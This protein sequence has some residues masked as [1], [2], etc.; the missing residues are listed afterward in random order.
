[1]ERLAMN[2]E[3]LKPKALPTTKTVAETGTRYFK[4]DTAPAHYTFIEIEISH[5]IMEMKT[6]VHNCHRMYYDISK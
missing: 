3:L 1:V 5:V 4:Q 2:P 6:E